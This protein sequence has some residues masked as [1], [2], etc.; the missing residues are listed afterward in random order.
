MISG[1]PGRATR[2][3][4]ALRWAVGLALAALALWVLLRGLEWDAI[5]GALTTADYRWVGLGV[6][7]VLATLVTRT[8]RWQALLNG[9]RVS[10]GSAA[11][12]ILVGQVVNTGLP[13]MRS[14]DF[15]RAAWTSQREA[16]GVTQALGA[17]VLE[18]VWDLLA[19]GVSGLALLIL[20]PLPTWFVQSTWGV[21]VAVGLAMLA[22][23]V[24]LRWQVPLLRLVGRLMHLL[25]ERLSSFLVPQLHELVASLDAIRQPRASAAAGLWT[26]T[27]WLLGGVTNWAVMQAFG[28]RSVYGATFLLVALMLGGAA[29]PTPGRIGVFEGISV[30][31]LTQFGVEPNLALA[32]GLV[33]HVAVMGPPLVLAAL[34]GLANALGLGLP[35]RSHD[36][37]AR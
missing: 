36:L 29:V 12:A 18:K 1:R 15:A 21:L 26:I 8:L 5:V 35:N 22:L 28:I 23:W 33:L 19:L 37:G 2:L 31:S 17:I 20:I 13:L 7:A 9:Q 4:A 34:L 30:V 16:V 25:P 3:T 10:F 6:A 32:T 11:T 24:G 27:T 14:G